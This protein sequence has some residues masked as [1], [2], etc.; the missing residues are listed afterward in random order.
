MN[1]LLIVNNRVSGKT[2]RNYETPFR[3]TGQ[4]LRKYTRDRGGHWPCLSAYQTPAHIRRSTKD[5]FITIVMHYAWQEVGLVNHSMKSYMAPI[6]DFKKTSQDKSIAAHQL[7]V[8]RGS[9]VHH[10]VTVLSPQI[11]WCQS[12]Q[13]HLFFVRFCSLNLVLRHN[14]KGF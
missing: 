4:L 6:L 1:W 8:V 13:T 10:E 3:I 2:V 14:A 5:G 12:K 11:N 7:P 9:H